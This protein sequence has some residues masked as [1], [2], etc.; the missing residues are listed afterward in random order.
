MP[1][2]R[3]NRGRAARSPC[4]RARSATSTHEDLQ[5]AQHRS[6]A[7]AALSTATLE[8]LLLLS[9][10]SL[11]SHLKTHA[12][13]SSGNKATMANRLY[14]YFHTSRL[15]PSTNSGNSMAPSDY[16]TTR[17]TGQSTTAVSNSVEI[18]PASRFREN[19]DNPTITASSTAAAA[20]SSCNILPPALQE[21]EQPLSWPE[22]GSNFPVQLAHQLTNLF[23]QFMPVDNRMNETASQT[24]PPLQPMTVSNCSAISQFPASGASGVT[25]TCQMPS[26]CIQ[27]V[28]AINTPVT[29]NNSSLRGGNQ[30]PTA[31][32]EVLS[33]ASP[34][35]P[36]TLTTNPHPIRH[37]SESLLT[38]PLPMNSNQRGIIMD[39]LQQS[40]PPVPAKIKERIIKGE[41]I[42]LTTLLPKAMLSSNV[43]P[44]HPGSLTL[45][46]P[47]GPSNFTVQ[48]AAK[49][50]KITSFSSWM[51]AWNIYLA[52]RVDF[53]PSSA[54]SLIAYQR[55]ITSASVSYPL[56]SWL[57]Y[58]VQFRMLAASNPSLR[59]DTR[60]HDL[61]L[62]C[63]TPSSVQQS[64]RWP[65]PFCGATNHFPNRCP[66]RANSSRQLPSGQRNDTG[67]QSSGASKSVTFS[68]NPSSN[69]RPGYVYCW[70]FNFSSCRRD[71]CKF[72]HVCKYCGANH[73]ARSCFRSGPIRST[74]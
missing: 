64:S 66:F 43:E 9:A 39:S 60:H 22:S 48:P 13:P 11:R 42:D 68:K 67:G 51:E 4:K 57:N 70:D 58:D 50:R 40:L 33:A 30:L 53:A 20:Q 55:I 8:Q 25:T 52:I 29:T 21:N 18:P 31:T 44:D 49:G 61:W 65:C 46:L 16:T 71:Q 72:A 69:P 23:R 36:L 12:L 2:K 56:Q 73:P 47:S 59:W 34:T 17:N 14:N 7:E 27:P 63:I 41:Y 5:P 54:P 3:K 10:S 35:Q 74:H 62:Q 15:T 37:T 26:S 32:D 24:G 38:Q 6:A 1:P 45:Q 19:S 28:L